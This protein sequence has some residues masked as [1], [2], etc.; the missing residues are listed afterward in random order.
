MC[1][2]LHRCPDGYA[3]REGGDIRL[4]TPSSR[5]ARPLTDLACAAHPWWVSGRRSGWAEPGNLMDPRESFQEPP[6]LARGSPRG[7]PRVVEGTGE[8]SEVAR[9][10]L[11]VHWVIAEGPRESEGSSRGLLR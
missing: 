6:K 2:G 7:P 1:C 3:A 5:R 4:A 11:E 8:S 9:G 10:S